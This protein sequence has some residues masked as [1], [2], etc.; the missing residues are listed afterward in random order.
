MDGSPVIGEQ[1]SV[2]W[3]GI[4]MIAKAVIDGMAVRCCRET[5]V[6]MMT[7]KIWTLPEGEATWFAQGSLSKK[8]LR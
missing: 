5:Q 6:S 2:E 4:E 3:F 7:G 1:A 8:S